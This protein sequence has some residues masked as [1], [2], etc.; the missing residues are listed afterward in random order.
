MNLQHPKR[1]LPIMPVLVPPNF[2][3]KKERI[4]AALAAPSHTYTDLSPK[5]SVDAGI[6]D[7]ID[8]I[9]TLEG[10]VT[11][12]SCAGRISVFLEG[13]K[14]RAQCNDP[15]VGRDEG[16]QEEEGEEEDIF[17]ER[18]VMGPVG[19]K[20]RGGRWLFVSHDPIE[21]P[22]QA[23]VETRPLSTLFGL[24][25]SLSSSSSPAA[26]PILHSPS[27]SR[28]VRFQFEPMVRL[29]MNIKSNIS[30][31]YSIK[32]PQLKP[33]PSID[34]P[35]PNRLPIPRPQ[36]PHRR[37]RGRIPRI[38]PL[39]SPHP[40]RPTNILPHRRRPFIRPLLVFSNRNH[41]SFRFRF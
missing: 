15:V 5:G 1:H 29:R 10:I 18:A 34:P 35:H 31:S 39:L 41:T 26:Q 2:T 13:T 17:D 33:P 7:L 40:H 11:T 14:P 28:L 30:I 23:E 24:T 38:R 21:I 8:R 16:E 27:Q 20:G 36:N 19:G 25:S 4:L 6:K 9:N 12:S 32:V 22:L 37:S 3:L